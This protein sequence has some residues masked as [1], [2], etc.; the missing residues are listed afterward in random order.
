MGGNRPLAERPP[1]AVGDP[2]GA[3]LDDDV[4]RDLRDVEI[5]ECGGLDEAADETH[6]AHGDGE[7]G[8][9]AETDYGACVT[10]S[11]IS[12]SLP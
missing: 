10:S 4:G 12:I 5:E 1:A 8:L 6:V 11:R 2:V 7:S 9:L 3:D